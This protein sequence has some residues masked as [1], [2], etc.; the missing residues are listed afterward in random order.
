[1]ELFFRRA[2][3]AGC[4]LFVTQFCSAQPVITEYFTMREAFK[5]DLNDKK[6]QKTIYTKGVLDIVWNAPNFILAITYDP[7]TTDSKEV[8][9]TIQD[10]VKLNTAGIVSTPNTK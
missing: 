7:R 6:I 4:F 1:M 2:L 9:K 10:V 8:M 5:I 3:S